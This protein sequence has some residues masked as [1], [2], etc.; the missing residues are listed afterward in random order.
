MAAVLL[1]ACHKNGKTPEEEVAT[2]PLVTQVGAPTG[3]QVS[4]TIG[5]QGGQ[6]ATADGH[7]KIIVP[8]GAVTTNQTFSLQP[9]EN[10][11]RPGEEA[12]H[13]SFK[14][15]PEGTTFNKPITVVMQYDPASITG[16]TEGLLQVAWQDAAGRWKRMPAVLNKTAHTLTVQTTH[17]S[18]WTFYNQFDVFCDKQLLR[19][20]EKSLFKVAFQPTATDD[21]SILL[22]PLTPYITGEQGGKGNNYEKLPQS[23]GP[24]VKGWKVVSGGGTIAGKDNGNGI[25]GEAEYTAPANIEQPTDVTIEVS[26]ESSMEIPDPTSPDGKRPL[27]QLIIRKKI[28]IMPDNYAVATVDGVNYTFGVALEAMAENGLTAMAGSN[29]EARLHFTI[30]VGAMVAGGYSCGQAEANTGKAFISLSHENS[31]NG[32]V[33]STSTYCAAENNQTVPKYSAGTLNITQLG[34]RGGFIEGQWSGLL[35]NPIQ[36]TN[37]E[38]K[39]KKVTIQF[40]IKRANY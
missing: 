4:A 3:P 15:L 40:R 31:S 37:C 12:S 6:L 35:Y 34:A 7:I 13:P 14:L 19:P 17:F 24:I 22:A 10:T 2:V 16:G 38:F 5:T 32:P 11:L 28:K 8:A 29:F 33:L 26:L 27:G 18:I 36:D 1:A 30:N 21:D 25:L 20:G 39:T 9:V 23:F